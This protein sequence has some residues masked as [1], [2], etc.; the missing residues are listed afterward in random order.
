MQKIKTKKKSEILKKG[1][2][3]SGVAT[4]SIIQS[5]YIVCSSCSAYTLFM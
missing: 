3:R 1:K 4:M 2:E 5:R